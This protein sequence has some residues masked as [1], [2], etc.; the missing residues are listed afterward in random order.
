MSRGGCDGPSGLAPGFTFGFVF[1]VFLARKSTFA[2]N[3]DRWEIVAFQNT[4][5]AEGMDEK[6]V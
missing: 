1:F 5:I 4:K 6:T 3:R 2:R